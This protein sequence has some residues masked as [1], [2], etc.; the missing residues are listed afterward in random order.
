[1]TDSIPRRDTLKLL[2][3]AAA[4]PI[5]VRPLVRQMTPAPS[6]DL[7]EGLAALV[8]KHKMPGALLGIYRQGKVQTAAAGI[9]NLNTGAP[10]SPQ[11]CFL[12]GSITKVWTST[13]VMTFV[14]EGVIDLERPLIEYLPHL[15]FGDASVT[16]RVTTRHL[17]NHSSGLDAG[18]Y[19][20]E[21]GEGPAANRQYVDTLAQLGQ[22]HPLGAYSSY[23][24][25]GWV[26]AGHLMEFLTGKSWHH[27]LTERVIK[28]LGASRT[29][30]DAEDGAL[31]G[32]VVGSVPDPKRPGEHMATPKF[33]L[34]KTIAPAG[35]TLLTT[36][37][38][39][40][41]L[42]RMHMQGGVAPSGNRVIS[43]KSAR[44]MATRTID[45]PSGPAS[46]FGLGW[47]HSTPG[48]KVTLSHSGGSNG[49]RAILTVVPD[50]DF[51]WAGFV[52]SNASD[53]FLVD[54]AAW[55]R[56]E[57]QPNAPPEPP[58]VETAAGPFDQSK[59]VGVYRRTTTKTTIRQEGEVLSVE[60]EWIAAEAPG[61]EAYMIGRPVRFPMRPSAP[62]AL[63]PAAAPPGSRPTPWIF[64]EPDNRGKFGLMY[65]G[66]RL[67]RRIDG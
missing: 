67:S 3:L 41:L 17:L 39:N 34:P 49:G 65:A 40:L 60:S 47:F 61:T 26:L 8:A 31:Y 14:D 13:L 33:L 56:K 23:N 11:L 7:S 38:D 35:S 62:N 46:G 18:D 59:F 2:L 9:A 27:L 36:L 51:A 6:D 24:N 64:L 12:T 48:G 58:P 28:P 43:E 57:H 66:T 5:G 30:P 4:M 19:V 55:V 21:F 32:V 50:S 63:V 52:N 54:F 29:Y 20:A 25:A 42:A 16:R 44:A 1:M 15:K 53:A 10:M 45:H 22:I 37:E